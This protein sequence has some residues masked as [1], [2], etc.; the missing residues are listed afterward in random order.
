MSQKI[1][2][3]GGGQMAE[4]LIK[5]IIASGLYKEENILVAEPNSFRRD[6]LESNYAVKAYYSNLPIFENCKNIILAVKPQ[7][8]KTLL[9]ECRERVQIQHILI[10][11]AAGL[12]ISFYID[13]L[14]KPETKVVRVMPNTPALVLEGASAL[15]RNRNV[16][17]SELHEAEE[18]FMAVG[19][20]VILDETHLDA[21]TGLS[22]SGPAYVFSFVEALIDAGVKS[23]LTRAVSEK[24]ALQTVSGSV[25]LLRESGE[26]PA[27]LRGMVTSPGGTAITALHVLEKVGFHGIIMDIVESAVNRSKQLGEAQ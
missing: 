14:G 19:E 6:H 8:M 18:I 22:G 17:D 12:P 10:S 16:S 1:G 20:V 26:H 5:G 21:V 25:K 23:G 2:F 7:T 13:T 4:A 3:I 11:I 9:E 15:S 27:A 24:L